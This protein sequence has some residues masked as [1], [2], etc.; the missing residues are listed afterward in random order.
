MTKLQELQQDLAHPN[1]SA[2]L[3]AVAIGET[4]T[5]HPDAWRALFGWH[6]VKNPTRVFKSYAE[7][8]RD[9]T[10]ERYDGEFLKNGKIDFT[11][12]AGRLQITMSTWD[13]F[14]RAVGEKLDFS[15]A[16]QR[17]C[18]VWLIRR[19]GAME[20]LK[21]GRFEEF[22]RKCRGT[23]ASLPGAG[24][25]QP[26][27]ALA[28]VRDAYVQ[29]G[30]TFAPLQPDLTMPSDFEPDT[31]KYEHYG[32]ETPMEP[33]TAISLAA[34]LAGKLIDI[35]SPLAQEK[36]TKEI[37]R[38]TD[39][40]KI[41]DQIA[42]TVIE[43]AKA[44]TGKDDPV[45]AVAAARANPGAMAA[46]EARTLDNLAKLAPV[47]DKV[48]ELEAKAWA[49]EE[50]SRDAAAT[51]ARGDAQDLAP[52]LANWAVK[53]LVGMIV[54]LAAIIIVQIIVS[55]DHKPMGELVTALTGMM[56]LYAGKT[57][58][59]YDYRFGSSRSSGAKDIVI[60]EISRK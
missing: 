38:H 51:R 26:E 47:L 21:A 42:G 57:N 3:T 30:G 46:I 35:F 9:R 12:A 60:S 13:D 37:A 34:G 11:T 16:S 22:V 52:M 32:E 55:P 43:A 41:A 54:T 1:V 48:A 36:L 31:L 24:T 44:V 50:A 28:K 27:V 25:G 4:G 19:A 17:L 20:D 14:L 2:G 58:T 18:G 7:H 40:P 5:E 59:V 15:P 33:F 6:R 8:P 53:G 45:D 56:M 10:Y 23:W 39:N 49:A 29:A